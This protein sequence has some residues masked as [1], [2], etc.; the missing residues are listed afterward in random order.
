MVLREV[1]WRGSLKLRWKYGDIWKHGSYFYDLNIVIFIQI[2][3]LEVTNLIIH[4]K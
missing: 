2:T 3:A 4:L 1:R